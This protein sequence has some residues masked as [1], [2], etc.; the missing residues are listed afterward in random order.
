MKNMKNK[1]IINVHYQY[2][3]HKLSFQK[4]VDLLFAPFYGL[5]FDDSDGDIENIIRFETDD[6]KR[7]TIMYENKTNQFNVDVRINLR[8]HITSESFDD[9][10]YMFKETGWIITNYSDR[11]FG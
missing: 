2:G 6:Y 5:W 8:Q 7:T 10:I 9:I 1:T 3:G 11:I 4:E